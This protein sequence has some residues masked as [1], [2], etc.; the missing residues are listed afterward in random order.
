MSPRSAMITFGASIVFMLIWLTQSGL[1]FK[2]SVIFI[3]LLMLI[4]LGISRV[5]C[6]SGIF[7]VVPPMIAQNP[8]IHLFSPR[9]IGAQG[10]SSLGLTY[11]WHGDVQSVVSG[12]S[13]EGVKLQSAIGCTGR[14]LTGL[15]LFA[16]GVGLLVAPWGV[17]LSGY[18]QGAI[19]WNTWLFRGFGPNTYGQVLTQLE[20]SM[21]QEQILQRLVY[22]GIGGLLTVGLTIMYYQF[23]WWPIHPIGLAIISSFT[24]YTV[25]LGFFI[26]WACKH[27]ILRWGGLRLYARGIPF[28]IGLL[29]GHYLG[30]A[31]ALTIYTIYGLQFA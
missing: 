4:Y 8:C 23:L 25:Y 24:L 1:Q 22:F 29:I 13:A 26:T 17:I 20:S 2:I 19:N 18:W 11:A 16:L 15:I 30:R 5:I 28:F 21:G 14:Q 3:P 12:L 7:Y 6:Q 10:M 27:T 9:R 31:V